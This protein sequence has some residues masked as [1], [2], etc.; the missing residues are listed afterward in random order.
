MFGKRGFPY[1][2]L[3]FVSAAI[4]L[5]QLGNPLAGGHSDE[6]L[7][8]GIAREM[9]RNHTWIVPTYHGAPAFY[10]PPLLYWMMI[11]AFKLFGN[12]LFAARLPAALF[13]I[14]TVLITAMLG[15]K[16][17]GDRG[18]L[19]G[20]LLL[21]TIPGMYAYGR[22]SLMDIPLVFFITLALYFGVRAAD[23]KRDWLFGFSF[24]SI[25]VAGLLKGP[26]GCLI[27]AIPLLW[28]TLRTN[29][30]ENLRTWKP[31]AAAAAALLILAFWPIMLVFRG[32][33]ESWLH[34]FVFQEN[35]GKF[36]SHLDPTTHP[37]PISVIWIH[38]F[39][40]FLPWS[41]F[42]LAAALLYILNKEARENYYPFLMIWI[43][44][45]GLI[46]M[47]PAKKLSHYTLPAIPPCALLVTGLIPTFRTHLA[48][49]IAFKLTALVFA[50][51]GI[52]LLLFSRIASTHQDAFILIAASFSFLIGAFLLLRK[53]L[54][55]VSRCAAIFL[56][57]YAAGLPHLMSTLDVNR[58]K[59]IAQGK[60]INGY[61]LDLGILGTSL[62]SEATTVDNPRLA[63]GIVILKESDRIDFQKAGVPITAPLLTWEAWKDH[64][65]LLDIL[66]AIIARNPT[67]IRQKIAIIEIDG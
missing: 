35:F 16:L 39:S 30:W 14:G 10:K 54:P 3:G 12:T 47:L 58:F 31:I 67:L 51:V 23:E 21:T 26:V 40:Q 6:P 32:Y 22:A 8:I 7:Y 11:A 28:I 5:T 43:L 25:G 53:R 61:R 4:F 44:T 1:F 19:A 24:L 41:F 13:G 46:F 36:S 9:F 62:D 37:T 29:S 57:L 59:E 45:V 18:R 33:G 2:L 65:R 27:P 20:W 42:L 60:P 50:L 48:S 52:L 38:L 55:E 17:F 64:I 34:F 15:E 66:Q 63:H 56:V 49:R